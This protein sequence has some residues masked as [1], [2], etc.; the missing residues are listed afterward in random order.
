MGV[1]QNRPFQLSFN[2][3][4]KI[5]SKGSRVTS[6]GGLM[7]VRELDKMFGLRRSHRPPPGR[8]MARR[9]YTASTGRPVDEYINSTRDRHH[10]KVVTNSVHRRLIISRTPEIDGMRYRS[11]EKQALIQFADL[12]M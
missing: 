7:M 11:P 4:L 3:S 1:K 12:D 2:S 8:F 5:D 10:L 6:D 9:K